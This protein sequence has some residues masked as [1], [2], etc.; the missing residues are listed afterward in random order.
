MF[1][2]GAAVPASVN[3]LTYEQAISYFTKLK[4]FLS[5]DLLSTLDTL[6]MTAILGIVAGILQLFSSTGALMWVCAKECD[7]L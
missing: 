6:Q 7:Y 4:Q 2:S 5:P 1:L 3:S